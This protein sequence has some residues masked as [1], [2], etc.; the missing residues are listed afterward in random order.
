MKRLTVLVSLALVLAATPAA[1]D[2]VANL[3]V[4]PAGS[5][6]ANGRTAAT[7]FATIQHALDAAPSGAI[8]HLAV[9][10][11]WQDAV[12]VRPGVTILGPP[13]AV[14]RGAGGARILQVQHDDV[15][16]AG[17]TIDGLAGDPGTADGYRDKLL[18]VMSTT[19]GDGVDGLKVH[20]MT[21]ANAGGE[22]V[23]LRYLITH[24][25][26]WNNRIGP[27]GVHDFVFA[28]GG[29][30]GEAI[31]VGTAPEQQ[32]K[33][34]AP[35]AAPDVSRDNWIHDNVI[36]TRGNECVDIKE[37]STANLV[38]G[39][40]CTGQ[41]DPNS[42]GFDARGNGNTFRYNTVIGSV[43]AGVRLGGD[44]AADGLDNDVYGNVITGNLAG[45]V[46]FQR[47]P[48]GVVC[49]NVMSG[50]VGGDAVGTYK[51]LFAPAAP[52]A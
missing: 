41:K 5:D 13:G 24:A 32:G 40:L 52:C 47:A 21:L 16:L 50:N 48:Q 36:D 9:G 34:G 17:F 7:P 3:F 27:C 26:V 23:R 28:G 2:P 1:A 38:E 20:D 35:D 6:A 45:G 44:T 11:Y 30:N 8:I 31:Y 51:A 22:C 33:N 29:K 14:L 37:N 43:G 15:T 46:K 4:S 19:P 10:E 39:N 25:E 12:T 18:Y 49:G 42:G